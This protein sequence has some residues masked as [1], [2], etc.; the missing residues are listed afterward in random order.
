MEDL[1]KEN[2]VLKE[3]LTPRL[4]INNE[5]NIANNNIDNTWI[6]VKANRGNNVN[7]KGSNRRFNSTDIRNKYQAIFIHE[8]EETEPHINNRMNLEFKNTFSKN[9]DS[10]VTIR[11][12][13]SISVIN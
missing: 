11:K 9:L 4:D 13:T 12:R 6:K 8:N 10:N 7:N 2:Q 1:K 3:T 5:N